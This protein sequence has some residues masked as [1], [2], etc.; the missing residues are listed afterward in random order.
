[1]FQECGFMFSNDFKYDPNL[2]EHYMYLAQKSLTEGI[3]YTIDAWHQ[4]PDH[5]IQTLKACG[6]PI[7]KLVVRDPLDKGLTGRLVQEL[8]KQ[9]CIRQ[10]CFRGVD[11]KKMPVFQNIIDMLATLNQPIEKISFRHNN[12]PSRPGNSL[13]AVGPVPF[14]EGGLTLADLFS[15]PILRDKPVSMKSP[16]PK[17]LPFWE[18]LATVVPGVSTL[19]IKEATQK[20]YKGFLIYGGLQKF[21]IK[22]LKMRG[23]NTNFIECCLNLHTL[24]V[25]L[26]PDELCPDTGMAELAEL[27][28]VAFYNTIGSLKNLT[29]L[30]LTGFH[31]KTKTTFDVLK[32]LP[33]LAKI[34]PVGLGLLDHKKPITIEEAGEKYREKELQDFYRHHRYH[35][36]RYML[37]L[38]N[39]LQI[40]RILGA[41]KT[42]DGKPCKGFRQEIADEVFS[43]TL[44]PKKPVASDMQ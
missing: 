31:P 30:T 24:C 18:S 43:F 36:Q 26:F 4:N 27:A 34:T 13:F 11:F 19:S 38:L 14:M 5:L 2:I 17:K 6:R 23:A 3:L 10:V 20:Y 39:Q 12:W 41:T 28:E 25:E 9:L 1:M 40:R 21:P 44:P 35:K 33:N 42:V 16:Q 8:S 37:P 29:R 15:N 32:A 22:T 7:T